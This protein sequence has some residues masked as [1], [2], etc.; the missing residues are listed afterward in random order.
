MVYN[1][2]TYDSPVLPFDEG[3]PAECDP[4]GLF[5]M[6][7]DGRVGGFFQ[8]RANTGASLAATWTGITFQELPAVGT[9]VANGATIQTRTF[10]DCPI[11]TLTTVNNYPGSIEITDVMDPLCVGFA[12]LHSWSFSEDGGI[13]A[14]PYHN[15]SQFHFG[16]DF[17][18]EGAGDGEGGLRISPWYGKF[19]D[20]RF[21]VSDHRRRDRLLR[22]S[23]PLLQLHRQPRHHVRQ[24]HDDPPGDDLRRA[25]SGLDRPGHDSV[26]GGLQRQHV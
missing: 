20:G 2:N 11:S 21:N 9:P 24:G 1:G 26:S 12:N 3:N 22:R 4:N 15:N 5:G 7:N 10:N 16:A 25:R 14:A 19:V 6:L 8:P 17:K 23:A 13:T 18:M